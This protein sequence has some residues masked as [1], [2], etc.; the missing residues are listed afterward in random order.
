L[1]NANPLEPTKQMIAE[2]TGAYKEHS[3]EVTVPA[4]SGVEYKLHMLK[5]EAIRCS[6][7]SAGEV[8]FFNFHGEPKGDTTG[9]FESYKVIL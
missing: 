9:Y 8:L 6:W 3:T 4:G 2:Q 5:G 7:N 1:A